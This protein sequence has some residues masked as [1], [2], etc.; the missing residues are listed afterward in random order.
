MLKRGEAAVNNYNRLAYTDED[1]MIL[2]QY[3]GATTPAKLFSKFNKD[4]KLNCTSS[5]FNCSKT[6]SAS[7]KKDNWKSKNIELILM[8]LLEHENH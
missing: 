3:E 7:R 1:K 5:A 4:S 8:Q 2:C 6:T